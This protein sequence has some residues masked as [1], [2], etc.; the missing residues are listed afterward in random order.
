MVSSELIES[1]S[2]CQEELWEKQEWVW[3]GFG[4]I[5]SVFFVQAKTWTSRSIILKQTVTSMI[6][7]VSSLG[8]TSYKHIVEENMG[9]GLKF[10][11]GRYDCR[12]CKSWCIWQI[13]MSQLAFNI[14]K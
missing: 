13:Y 2:K 11:L 6:Y 1:D 10:M 9:F 4:V 5:F 7:D 14:S 8:R 12:V 3:N